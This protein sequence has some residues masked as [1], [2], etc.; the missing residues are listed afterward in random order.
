MMPLMYAKPRSLV[1]C[2]LAV[3]ISLPLTFLT[4]TI[5]RADVSIGGQAV[6]ITT[7]GDTLTVRS[8]PGRQ[9]STIGALAQGTVV[10]VL[11][12]PQSSDDGLSWVQVQGAGLTGWCSAEWLGDPASAPAASPAAPAATPPSVTASVPP[13][14]APSGTPDPGST[15]SGSGSPRVSGT[16]GRGAHLRATP[17]LSGAI[18]TVVPEGAEVTVTGANVTAEGY[19]W[20]PVTYLDMSGWVASGLLAAAAAAPAVAAPATPTPA[21]IPVSA[22][23]PTPT[24]AAPTAVPATPAVAPTGAPAGGVGVTVGG[25][26]MIVGTDGFSLRIRAKPGLD[27]PIVSFAPPGAIVAVTAGPQND[28]TGA[29]W[30][31]I[32][33]GGSSGW[34]LG[35]HVAP[36]T[37][38]TAAAPP[39]PAAPAASATPAPNVTAAPTATPSPATTPVAA[40]NRGQTV[41]AT[42]LRYLG[43]PYVYGGTTPSG[44]DCS[45]FVAYVYQTGVGIT[46]PRSAAQQYRVGTTIG[47]AQVQAGDIV[48]FS[49]TFGPGI[50]HDGIALG[51]G[52][53]IHARSEG[54]GTVISSLSDPYW[55]GH[56]AGAQRP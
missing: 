35:E 18:V 25:N 7:E 53:F 13:T 4:P 3:L 15:L 37:G 20:V 45:G 34:V 11:A 50:T 21:I 30:Y 43:V 8:G 36:V 2:F 42:A 29:P 22:P 46:L 31:G 41:V 48:F 44:W 10:A 47:A 16:D 33:Y 23:L 14:V 55:G 52:R 26:A 56:F 51:D 27:A 19:A 12:G 38:T 6:V 49:D 5:A 54:Y 32:T 28:S 17:S 39:P 40:G 1:T 9:F 24:T